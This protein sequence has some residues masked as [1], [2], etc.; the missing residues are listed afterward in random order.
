MSALGHKRKFSVV[1]AI[2]ALPPKADIET[3]VGKGNR[4]PPCGSRGQFTD[5]RQARIR[6]SPCLLLIPK[7]EAS[8]GSDA[9]QLLAKVERR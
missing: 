5:E 1:C 3:L 2:S 8:S 4:R 7:S 9:R 6:A